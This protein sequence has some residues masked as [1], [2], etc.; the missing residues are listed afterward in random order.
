M[1]ED[2]TFTRAVYIEFLSLFARIEK[3][4]T[5]FFYYLILVDLRSDPYFTVN[6]VHY[7]QVFS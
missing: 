4:Q 7:E 6:N 3:D 1:L 2:D 5:V